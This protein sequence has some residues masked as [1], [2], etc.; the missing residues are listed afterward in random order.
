MMQR[1][2]TA[3]EGTASSEIMLRATTL[4]TETIHGFEIHSKPTS[5]RGRQLKPED[6]TTSPSRRTGAS[7]IT[8]GGEETDPSMRRRSRDS[9][10][11]TDFMR[12]SLD[13]V[14]VRKRRT[15]KSIQKKDENSSS[16]PSTST[17]SGDVATSTPSTRYLIISPVVLPFTNSLCPPG[18]PS[19]GLSR[20][21]RQTNSSS[22]GGSQFLSN[23]TLAVFGSKDV[24][25]SSK[26]LRSWAEKQSKSSRSRFEWEDIEGAGHFWS[27]EDAMER[28]QTRIESWVK[29]S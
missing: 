27:E 8:V 16:A 21:G 11:S 17:S 26:R 7:S 13:K 3:A 29:L 6:A 9:R 12:K 1:F 20:F 22:S 10:R 14:H 18:P 28:L 4:A 19:I 15:S 2:E 23:P 25:T 5:P 24:F